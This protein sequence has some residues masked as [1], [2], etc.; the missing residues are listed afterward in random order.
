ME[1]K[2]GAIAIIALNLSKMALNIRV[3]FFQSLGKK[4]HGDC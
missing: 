2:Y 1:R 3:D 4:S